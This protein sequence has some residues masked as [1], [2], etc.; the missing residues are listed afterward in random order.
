M[1]RLREG[2]RENQEGREKKL[3]VR[4]KLERE[5]GIYRKGEVKMKI[6][7]E[8]GKFEKERE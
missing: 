4:E 6:E 2:E 5:S 3:E 8:R 1:I 7:K